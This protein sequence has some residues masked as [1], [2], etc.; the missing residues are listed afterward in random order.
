[1]QF[2]C[3]KRKKAVVGLSPFGRRGHPHL[4]IAAAVGANY[5][6]FDA[7]LTT[8]GRKPDVKGDARLGST[9]GRS[10]RGQISDPK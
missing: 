4:E 5:P 9:P 7:I 2:A 6:A 1:M 10:L 8:L 3:E